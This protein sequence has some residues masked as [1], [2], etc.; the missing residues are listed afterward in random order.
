MILADTLPSFKT[1]LRKAKLP[2][3]AFE[4]VLAFTAT[5]LLHIGPMSVA[6]A[7]R[8][9]RRH[10]STLTRF[11]WEVGL[12]ADLLAC[13][14]AATLL[15]EQQTNASGIWLFAVDAT[16]RHTQAR[17]PENAYSCR[18]KNKKRGPSK[19]SR[20]Q[21]KHQPRKC[22]SFVCGLLLTPGGL[23]LP[24]WLPYYTKEF[25]A[26]LGRQHKTE[27]DL[28]AQL[29]DELELP[30]GAELVV[31]G[32]TAYE[33]EQV[34]KACRRRGCWWVAP[35]NPERVLVGKKPRRQV[36]ELEQELTEK[37]F[38]HVRLSLKHGPCSQQR[39]LSASRGGPGKQ[40]KRDYWVH[41]R[42]AD[43]HHVGL[44]V[45]LFSKTSKPRPGEKVNSDKL[46]L[47]NALQAGAEQ[48][49]LWY[50]LRWQIELFFKE[51]KSVLGLG[52]YRV[53]KFVQVKGWV[54]L[55]L[56]AFCYLEWYRARHL[57]QGGLSDEQRRDWSCARSWRLCQLIRLR[58]RHEELERL[59]R[60]A[61]TPT[62]RRK[63]K[64]ALRDACLAATP[65]QQPA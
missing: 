7:A 41:R 20:K 58:M 48:L 39:R 15:L 42:I 49:T 28:A 23:R 55:C 35:C 18:N 19:S 2:D 36:R 6:Q 60:W 27:A 40:P 10:I 29:I 12:S 3:W 26:Q 8:F 5:F 53:P 4:H 13:A 45:L 44:V 14:R 37:S 24:Y 17:H 47:S 50:S 31:V 30:A 63:L 33:A 57:L 32:D 25:C 62:G 46:L 21:L 16:K 59:Y 11:L 51:C 54:E 64:R 61:C 56:L 34:Q 38:E 52:Q 43:V 22:H 65:V 1:F 9:N